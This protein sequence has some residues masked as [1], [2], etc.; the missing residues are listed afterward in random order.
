MISTVSI[1]KYI[2]V[3]QMIVAAAVNFFINGIISWATFR[4]FESLS[5]WDSNP[6]YPDILLTALLLPL[7]SCLINSRLI[8]RK[9]K[10]G[11]LQLRTSPRIPKIGAH[12]MTVFKR[13]IVLGLITLFCVGSATLM[14]L[15]V[16]FPNDINVMDYV[17]FKSFWSSVLALFLAYPIAMWSIRRQV[18]AIIDSRV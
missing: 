14:L 17:L 8:E 5:V 2:V 18:Q 12:T 10:D 15:K 13:S 16:I 4:Q 7:L 9:I 1:R 11:T 3:D 6:V